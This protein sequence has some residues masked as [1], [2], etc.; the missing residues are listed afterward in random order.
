MRVIGCSGFVLLNRAFSETSWIVEL[1]TR[2]YGRF[3]VIAKGARRLK[4]KQRGLLLPFQPLRLSWSGKGE[5]PTLT[6]VEM[7]TGR[8]VGWQQELSGSAR[9]CGFYCNELLASLM[10]RGD[11]HPAL[12]DVYDQTITHLTRLSAS[13]TKWQESHLLR[14]FELALIKESGYGVSFTHDAHSQ[15]P[16]EDDVWYEFVPSKGFV[17]RYQRPNEAADGC[18]SGRALKDF[19]SAFSVASSNDVIDAA[20]DRDEGARSATAKRLTRVLLSDLL[21]HKRIV[22]RDLFI[23]IMVD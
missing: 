4:S 15:R 16:F 10:Q 9:L 19:Q 11:P 22:S 7:D 8:F 18:F 20:V 14:R 17:K 2:D 13:A 1:F 5:L 12:F 21:G 23:P 3:A 6:Q